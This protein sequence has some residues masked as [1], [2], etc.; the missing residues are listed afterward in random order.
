M[1]LI[2]AHKGKSAGDFN[3][4][5]NV[6]SNNNESVIKFKNKVIQPRDSRMKI[7][8]DMLYK[9]WQP[10]VIWT[11]RGVLL[12]LQD[13]VSLKCVLRVSVCVRERETMKQRLCAITSVTGCLPCTACDRQ[14][15]VEKLEWR[16]LYKWCCSVC[17]PYLMLPFHS[18]SVHISLSGLPCHFL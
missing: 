5:F 18:A 15:K 7:P 12:H 16:L 1:H 8:T 17:F 13:L 14:K 6:F 10:K 4:P 3:V 2:T 9:F 11:A